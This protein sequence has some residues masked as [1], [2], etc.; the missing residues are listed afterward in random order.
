M[1]LKDDSSNVKDDLCQ[2]RKRC[3][4]LIVSTEMCDDPQKDI[5]CFIKTKK[6]CILVS[7]TDTKPDFWKCCPD[8]LSG[9]KSVKIIEKIDTLYYAIG[10]RKKKKPI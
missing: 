4:L 10:G 1:D 3:L 7:F 8:A 5:F 9:K 6:I 2:I